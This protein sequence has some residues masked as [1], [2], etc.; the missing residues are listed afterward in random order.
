MML[1][2]TH[3]Q[4]KLCEVLKNDPRRTRKQL[5]EIMGKSPGSINQMLERMERRGIVR[6]NRGWL[7]IELLVDPFREAA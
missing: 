2:I 1:Q 4:L 7:G 6:I 3:K 5:G